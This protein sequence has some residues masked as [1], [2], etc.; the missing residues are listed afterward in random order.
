MFRIAP[1]RVSKRLPGLRAR[2]QAKRL[3]RSRQVAP[4]DVELC[5][6]DLSAETDINIISCSADSRLVIPCVD[7]LAVNK[8]V[9]KG[10]GRGVDWAKNDR[11]IGIIRP[12]VGKINV[13]ESAAARGSSHQHFENIVR[14]SSCA[15]PVNHSTACDIV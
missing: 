7:G 3:A 12:Q 5:N 1:A 15:S 9:R 13:P 6:G 14:P 11:W 10:K 2:A 4:A 8:P